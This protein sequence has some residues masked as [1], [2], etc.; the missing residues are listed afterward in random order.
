MIVT[1]VDHRGRE[2][3]VVIDGAAQATVA[4]LAVKLGPVIDGDASLPLVLLGPNGPL[5]PTAPLVEAGVVNGARLRLGGSVPSLATSPEGLSLVVISGPLAGSWFA[6]PMGRTVTAGSSERCDIHLDHNSVPPDALKLEVVEDGVRLVPLAGAG[7]LAGVPLPET[8]TDWPEDS[9]EL[10]ELGNLL[11]EL[12]KFPDADTK[13]SSLSAAGVYLGHRPPRLQSPRSDLAGLLRVLVTLAPPQIPSAALP[14][15]PMALPVVLAVT[16]TLLTRNP[17]FLLSALAGILTPAVALSRRARQVRSSENGHRHAADRSLAVIREAR[18]LDRRAS[19]NPV[20]VRAAALS[21]STRLWE[22]RRG[23]A[24][25]LCLRVGTATTGQIVLGEN[26]IPDWVSKRVPELAVRD[27]PVTVDLRSLGPLGIVGAAARARSSALWLLTQAAGLHAPNDLQFYVLSAAAEAGPWY[28]MIWMPHLQ[29]SLGSDRALLIGNTGESRRRRLAELTATLDRRRIVASESPVEDVAF[30]EPDIIV[31]LDGAR[32]IRGLPGMAEVLKEGPRFGIHAICVDAELTHLPEECRAVLHVEGCTPRS[33]RLDVAGSE[34]IEVRADEVP[35]EIV[36]EVARALA[37]L[38]LAEDAADLGPVRLV[39]LLGVLTPTADSVVVGWRHPPRSPDAVVGVAPDGEL[40]LDFAADGPHA[41]IAGTT[42]S[43]KTELLRTLVTSLALTHSPDQLNFLLID[44]KGGSAFGDAAGLPHTLG[45]VTY[46]DGHDGL[47]LL[48]WLTAEVGRRQ[49]A[50]R[51]VGAADIVDYH[52]AD[53]RFAGEMA[54]LVVAVDE[55]AEFAHEVPEI[56]QGLIDITRRGRS[57]GVHVVLATQQ[58]TNAVTAAIKSNMNLRIALRMLNSADSRDVLDSPIAATIA[59]RTPGR[60]FIRSGHGLPRQFQTAWVSGRDDSD[61]E[62]LVVSA[63]S[64]F[65]LGTERGQVRR[66]VDYEAPTELEHLAVVIRE[67]AATSELQPRGPVWLPAL[68]ALIPLAS[69]LADG[70]VPPARITFGVQDV[71]DE[72]C[73]R[74]A[75]LDLDQETPVAA[76]GPSQSGRTQWLRTLALSASLTA[77][78]ADLHLYVIGSAP[79]VAATVDLPHCG[80]AVRI[81]D[82]DRV[83]RLASWLERELRSRQGLLAAGGFFSL[84]E[85]NHTVS[86]SEAVPRILCLIDDWNRLAR[87]TSGPSALSR[88]FSQLHIVLAEGRAVGIHIAFTANES[89]AEER[90]RTATTLRLGPRSDRDV[91]IPGRARFGEGDDIQIALADRSDQLLA[92][93]GGPDGTHLLPRVP[94]SRRP[95]RLVDPSLAADSFDPGGT[96]GRPVGREESLAWLRSRHASRTS[97]VLLGPR[98][99]GKT[100]ILS[101][102][103]RRL[104]T[105]G[106]NTVIR[107]T[108]PQPSAPVDTPDAVASLIYRP[109][110]DSNAPAEDLIDLAATSARLGDPLVFLLDE[111][112]RLRDYP[113]SAV[114][115]LR[116]LGQAGAWMVYSGTHRDWRRV[117]RWALLFPGSSFGN[118]VNVHELGPLRPGD[119]LEFLSGTAANLGVTVDPDTTGE[120]VLDLV[121]SWPFYLQVIGD[122]LVREARR[123]GRVDA[124]VVDLPQ[125]IEARLLD[126][127]SHHF[128][129]RFSEIGPLGRSALL[130]AVQPPPDPARLAPAQ[131]TELSSAGLLLANNRW[132]P[133]PPLYK[134]IMRNRQLLLDEESS[135]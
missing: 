86:P 20:D 27:M 106:A 80:T 102:L 1:V 55:Y 12:R 10:L 30:G 126:E 66:Q 4:D 122:A 119:A 125:L 112:G 111:V 38:K 113:S 26:A 107:L 94:P 7:S 104:T 98:R 33:T 101:E 127:W 73:Q 89:G 91:R 25:F 77:S 62:S 21:R 28:P 128:H 129:G 109:L 83:A 103:A 15:V 133:D 35:Q 68:P 130:S 3:D 132:L 32:S 17:L 40:R 110:R 65:D 44:Y 78:P 95:F 19:P 61:L 24:D 5:D 117:V 75:A 56:V 124:G 72:Q 105:D 76:V 60:A 120:E 69:I 45:V 6:L 41:L 114:S 93:R 53:G 82:S 63:A 85:H 96:Q 51:R 57:L 79:L 87:V 37:P 134:W 39:E 23:D 13:M 92:L 81:D 43:G 70:P 100:W 84:P 67:A 135:G 31:L 48:R 116:D 2:H 36:E 58:P 121:G 47:R 22:R 88:S 11:C 34:A 131:R 115:W 29:A 52:R 71:P 108:I 49:A 90:P 8:P 97:A 16:L 99:A 42:G 74:P 14:W 9:D 59:Q 46:L 18:L 50:L 118:D 64:W 123:D 54:R